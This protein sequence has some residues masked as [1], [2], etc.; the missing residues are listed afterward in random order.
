MGSTYHAN[1]KIKWNAV[2]GSAYHD[3]GKV[4]YN[5]VSKSA[6]HDNGK[7]AYNSITKKFYDEKGSVIEKSTFSISLGKGIRMQILPNP[8]KIVVYDRKIA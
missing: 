1:K 4:A 2:S 8:V 5:S 7:V 6:Y 3:N